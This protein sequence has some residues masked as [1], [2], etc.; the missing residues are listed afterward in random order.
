MK[1]IEVLVS[2]KGESRIETHGYDGDSCRAATK[3]LERALGVL[4]TELLKPEFY[5]NQQP[6]IQQKE[7]Q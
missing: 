6:N 7:N 4:N 1:R 3:S 2:P 5:E